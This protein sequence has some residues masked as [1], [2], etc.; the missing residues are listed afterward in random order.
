V[1]GDLLEITAG[2]RTLRITA[3]LVAGHADDAV[4]VHF[5]YG[6]DGE[7]EIAR[8]AGVNVYPFWTGEGFSIGGAAISRVTGSKRR[9]FAVTQPHHTLAT[10][11]AAR[12]MTLREYPGLPPPARSGGAA[13]LYEPPVALPDGPAPQQWGMTIDLGACVGCGACMVACQAENNV[14]VVGRDEVLRGRAM[15][16]LRI[17]WYQAS[18]GEPPAISQPM[19]CQHCEMAPCE[20]VCPVQATVHSRDGLNEMVYNRCVGTRFC[21]N[22]CPY[23]VRRFNWIDY[24]ARLG[25]GER[26]VKNPDVTVRERGVMEKCTFCVQRIRQA[27][28]AARTEGR[29]LSGRDVQTACQQSCPTRAIVFGSLTEPDSQL[30]RDRSSPRAYAV[31]KELGTRPRVL[32]LTRVRNVNPEL[33]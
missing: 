17:D 32:Y 33:E 24:N 12:R 15:H 23:K 1:S 11:E 21:S 8:G 6:R 31:L 22:N 30:Q 14:P 7:E 28:I 9:A 3:L 20:Y 25:P 19:L 18:S 4:T 2:G 13:S 10:T 26:L 27:E 5:G 29:T 16:W